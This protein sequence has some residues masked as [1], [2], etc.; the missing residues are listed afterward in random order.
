M[1]DCS[2]DARQNG[3]ECR[4][5]YKRLWIARKREREFDESRHDQQDRPV[6]LEVA[7]RAVDW[8]SYRQWAETE[9]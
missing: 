8:M 6:S 3:K 7:Q 5:C 1:P 2:N 9:L 4:R